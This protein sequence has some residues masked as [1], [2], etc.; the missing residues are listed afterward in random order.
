MR[1]MAATGKKQMI[2]F[3]NCVSEKGS[4]IF[5]SQNPT[6]NVVERGNLSVDDT[7]NSNRNRCKRSH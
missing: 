2:N 4:N 1:N 7:Q 5:I 6:P 3:S